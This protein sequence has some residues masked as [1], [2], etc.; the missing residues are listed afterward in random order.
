[1]TATLTPETAQ[2]KFEQLLLSLKGVAYPVLQAYLTESDGYH[3]KYALFIQ[4]DYPNDVL[5]FHD[6]EK[7]FDVY[8]AVFG[9]DINFVESFILVGQ[10][11]LIPKKHN[12][13]YNPGTGD[14]YTILA[15]AA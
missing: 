11:G 6:F 7:Y 1:M 2:L 15:H 8:K 9:D 14:T 10:Q 5:R 12:Q 3:D 13:V 4:V